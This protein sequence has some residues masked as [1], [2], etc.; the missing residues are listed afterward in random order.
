MELV[1]FECW[2]GISA[3]I[4]W[5]L[6]CGGQVEWYT[7]SGVAMPVLPD[8]CEQGFVKH[9]AEFVLLKELVVYEYGVL[10][11]IITVPHSG[12]IVKDFGL[13]DCAEG[14]QEVKSQN[15]ILTLALN[16]KEHLSYIFGVCPSIV[17]CKLSRRVLDVDVPEPEAYSD[18]GCRPHYRIYYES[19]CNSIR[20]MNRLHNRTPL[21]LNLR[22][23]FETNQ[24]LYLN[25]QNGETLK[26]MSARNDLND[27]RFH[28]QGIHSR[29]LASRWTVS[30]ERE[31]FTDNRKYALSHTVKYFSFSQTWRA[32]GVDML[33]PPALC[34][35]YGL[36]PLC[37]DLAE[38]VS[39]M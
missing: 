19:V 30:P 31:N 37:K 3:D 7:L 15:H 28:E 25:T 21:L 2:T 9:R 24:T 16:L 20:K 5:T 22:P 4:G 8:S 36:R 29:M 34:T 12:N 17:Y 1:F 35:G 27:V 38:S 26:K 33:L 14:C 11:I 13:R 18:S 23:H 32:D 10:P 6:V 39:H